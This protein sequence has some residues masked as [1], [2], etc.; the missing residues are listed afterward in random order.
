MNVLTFP[1]RCLKKNT[2]TPPSPSSL[3][4]ACPSVAPLMSEQTNSNEKKNEEMQPVGRCVCMCVCLWGWRI[5]ERG[6]VGEV[7]RCLFLRGE[8]DC[9]ERGTAACEC[10]SVICHA[11][12]RPH[13]AL[14]HWWLHPF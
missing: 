3:H 12:A 11:P 6:V 1:S 8:D 2:S 9:A 10:E 14:T 4:A 13:I 5:K 7:D